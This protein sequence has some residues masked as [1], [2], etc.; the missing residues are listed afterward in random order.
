VQRIIDNLQDLFSFEALDRSH[1]AHVQLA[2]KPDLGGTNSS[3]KRHFLDGS[4][5]V[6]PTKI[7]KLFDQIPSK[8]I[9][10]KDLLALP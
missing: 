4:R 5:R 1:W 6:H 10:D 9:C 3:S 8:V 7:P 2:V